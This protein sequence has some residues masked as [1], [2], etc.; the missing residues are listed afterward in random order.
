M[1]DRIDIA[2]IFSK[3]VEHS[4][5]NAEDLKEMCMMEEIASIEALDRQISI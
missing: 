3:E 1:F 5:G 2:R 4:E